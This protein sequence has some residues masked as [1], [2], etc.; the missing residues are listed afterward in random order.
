[1]KTT[2]LPSKTHL[3]PSDGRPLRGLASAA[4][5]PL[6][7]TASTLPVITQFA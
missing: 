1:M 4:A 6:S 2:L 5:T 7:V 3:V